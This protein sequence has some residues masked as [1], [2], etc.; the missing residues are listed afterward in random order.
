LRAILRA[1][2]LGKV[3]V[4]FPLVSTLLELRQAKMVLADVMEDLQEHNLPFDRNMPVGMMVET[5]AAA[6]MADR[7]VEEVDFLSIGTNDLIQYTLA[8]DRTNKDV[9][10]LYNPV[11]PAVL[12]LV[13]MA[14]EAAD[15]K[16]V[17][18]SMCGQMSGSPL[19]TILLLGMGL[20][21]F[22][23]TPSAIPEVKN[24]CRRVTIP[25]CRTVAERVMTMENARDVKNYLKEEVKKYVEEVA[26]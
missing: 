16:P 8:V 6:M 23:V 10:G 14:I 26:E 20:R 17:P 9:V 21:R 25:E 3:H 24:L 15:R 12:K 5:P 11:D 2:V 22:S 13:A 1:S 7:F 4:M 18:I 19:Y